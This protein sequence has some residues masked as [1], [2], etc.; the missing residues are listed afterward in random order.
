MGKISTTTLVL[1]QKLEKFGE[2]LLH[3]IVYDYQFIR[4]SVYVILG[5]LC[6]FLKEL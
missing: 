4:L 5:A 6:F 2:H 1:I 3:F